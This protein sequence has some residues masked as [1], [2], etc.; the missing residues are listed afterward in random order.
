MRNEANPFGRLLKDWRRLRGSSQLT[1]ALEAEIS[2][3]HLSFIENGRARPSRE[4]VMRLVEA[5][6]VPNRDRNLFLN[7]AGYADL[8][9]HSTL[10]AE[11]IAPAMGVLK[12]M[13]TKHEP[14]PAF[15]LDRMWNLLMAND[16]S[17]RLLNA[18]LGAA[19]ADPALAGNLLRLTL[20]PRGLRSIIENWATVARALV[21]RARREAASTYG[22]DPLKSLVAEVNEFPGIATLGEETCAATALLPVVPLT[23]SLDGKRLS[24]YS[25]IAT[26]G[27]PQD[28][29]LQEL[30][31]ETFA[32]V[33]ETTAAFA[34]TLAENTSTE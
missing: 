4:M 16:S 32:P 25:I 9:R 34:H 10:D 8:Y 21:V 23:L 7:A 17:Q 33:D 19:D 3:R 15:V 1:L 22:E 29:T 30:R 18:C 11:E 24:W 12:F 27:T 26:F 31:L 20:H 28:I 2:A 14:Y 13:L 5:L 6:D